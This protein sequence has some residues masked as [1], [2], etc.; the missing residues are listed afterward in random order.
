MADVSRTS[1]VGF[2]LLLLGGLAVIL[3]T[4]LFPGNHYSSD[5]LMIAVGFVIGVVLG[6]LIMLSG[7]A[8]I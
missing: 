4:G 8:L 1:V 5:P 7:F 2:V 3:V 6:G